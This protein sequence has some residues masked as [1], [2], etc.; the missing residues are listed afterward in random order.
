MRAAVE[1]RLTSLTFDAAPRPA[2]AV[3]TVIAGLR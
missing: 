3:E 1:R 2:S